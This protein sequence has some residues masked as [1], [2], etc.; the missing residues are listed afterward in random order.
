MKEEELLIKLKTLMNNTILKMDSDFFYKEIGVD[1]I[2]TQISNVYYAGGTLCVDVVGGKDDKGLIMLNISN[3]T[4]TII[5]KD[6]ETKHLM[7]I[8]TLWFA[9]YIYR[10]V[11]G[12][13]E[14]YKNCYNKSCIRH[15]YNSLMDRRTYV[16]SDIEDFVV[17]GYSRSAV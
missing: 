17:E 1:K 12:D 11:K 5:V 15:L 13:R 8:Q 3:E 6:K 16:N 7:N 10:L 9:F 2:D 14:Y 4:I